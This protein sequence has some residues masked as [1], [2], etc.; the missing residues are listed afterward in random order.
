MAE[1]KN[2]NQQGGGQDSRS[3]LIM[4]VVMV[5][6]FFGLQFFRAKNPQTVAPSAPAATQT[7]P[8]QN[9]DSDR[10]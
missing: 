5:A 8:A 1:F 4:I 9:G 3:F 10:P 7:S 6:V 2:P